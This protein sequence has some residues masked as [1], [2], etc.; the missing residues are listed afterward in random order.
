MRSW[1]TNLV[2]LFAMA[3]PGFAGGQP[4]DPER[5]WARVD[6]LARG[7]LLEVTLAT[8][9]TCTG[10]LRATTSD[11]VMLE[12]GQDRCPECG[13]ID[14]ASIGRVEVRRAGGARL[15]ALVG[16]AAMVAIEQAAARGCGLGCEND[17]PGSATMAAAAFGAGVG[18]LVGLVMDKAGRESGGD[19]IYPPQLSAVPRDTF[20]PSATVGTTFGVTTFRS[21]RIQGRSLTPGLRIAVQP[22][23]FVSGRI[24]YSVPVGRF[25][26]SPG[27]VP[28]DVLENV[29]PAPDRGAGWSRGI[30]SR[31]VRFLF[32]EFVGVHPPSLGPVRLTLL[33][34]LGVQA[35]ED[36]DYYALLDHARARPSGQ[37]YVLAFESP[38]V[39]PVA[40]L[41][42]EIV[43]PRG[44][45]IA[46]SARYTAVGDPG[47]ST[48]YG[49]GAQWRF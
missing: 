30:E 39:G 36:R 3:V 1:S 35:Q 31:R 19:V 11:R 41:D 23:R 45:V 40:G 44:I 18:S 32:S 17:R 20:R 21:S 14:K 33:A 26:R 37:S 29:V 38:R 2:V 4:A 24:E 34:G 49:I 12:S 43:L 47:P 27:A 8:G 13:E 48:T 25:N 22:W 15:G 28:V 16:A 42:A 10:R 6:A 7:T 9:A 5:P 46:P